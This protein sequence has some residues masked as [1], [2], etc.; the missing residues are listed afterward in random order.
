MSA[1]CRSSPIARGISTT[2]EA[3]KT[4]RGQHNLMVPVVR[5]SASRHR[6]KYN[7]TKRRGTRT[8][9]LRAPT[10]ICR[11]A[12]T[13]VRADRRRRDRPSTGASSSNAL[14][15]KTRS[16]CRRFAGR[17]PGRGSF[18]SQSVVKKRKG[19]VAQ[20]FGWTVTC[21]SK[22]LAYGHVYSTLRAAPRPRIRI[23]TSS[24]PTASSIEYSSLSEFQA[25]RF[26]KRGVSSF[27]PFI[28]RLLI[29]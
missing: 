28:I 17:S 29:W 1:R 26:A 4:R 15:R 7:V 11:L 3:P 25:L 18:R 2:G 21:W 14:G 9:S 6:W 12:M 10:G 16:A 27:Q 20:Q 8:Q 19:V 24:L 23:G 5:W 22:S 13:C